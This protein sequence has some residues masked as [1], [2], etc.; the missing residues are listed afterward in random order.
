MNPASLFAKHATHVRGLALCLML[1]PAMSAAETTD[2]VA[3]ALHASL[4]RNVAH[5]RE[6]LEG[7]DFKSLAQ[8][9]SGLQLLAEL[10]QA[11]SDDAAW[12]AAS[13]KV[14]AAISQLQE[15]ARDSDAARSKAGLEALE[16]AVAATATISAS[17]KPKSPAR[18]VA[19]RP[20]M[21]VLDSVYAD[22]KMASLTG[23]AAEAKK[24]AY[25][26]SELG[27]LVS[28]SQSAGSKGREKWPELG[29]SFVEAS[30]AAAL[31]PAEDA[32]TVKQLLRAVSQR[33]EACHE[34]RSR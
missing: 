28:N 8:S 6:W 22:A 34:T 13:G 14:L 9:A 33:C 12:Q 29:A 11:R 30:L 2:Q 16:K 18:Q 32:A 25:V 1:C 27:R 26:L 7:G 20:L 10:W 15:A 19:L 21:L 5:A 23:Q 24:T 4:N 31:S 3:V 17:G